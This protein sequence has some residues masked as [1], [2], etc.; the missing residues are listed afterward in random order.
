MRDAK[1]LTHHRFFYNTIFIQL[2]TIAIAKRERQADRSLN[3]LIACRVV[4][5]LNHWLN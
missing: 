5:T 2:Q 4:G 3:Y 1:Q